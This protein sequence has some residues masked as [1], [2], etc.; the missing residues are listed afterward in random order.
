MFED[1]TTRPC[2]I[3]WVGNSHILFQNGGFLPVAVLSYEDIQPL[4]VYSTLDKAKEALLEH[5]A[6]AEWQEI[7]EEL[8]LPPTTLAFGGEFE[9]GELQ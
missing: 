5:L 8:S 7:D 9:D 2:I 6:W 3:E 1:I 4:D